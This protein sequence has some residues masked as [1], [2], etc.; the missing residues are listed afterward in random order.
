MKNVKDNT[1]KRNAFLFNYFLKEI[2][3]KTKNLS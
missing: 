2:S 3:E 1:E